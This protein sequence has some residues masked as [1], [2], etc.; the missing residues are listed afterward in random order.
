MEPLLRYEIIQTFKSDIDYRNEFC[1]QHCVTN[2][3]G[4]AVVRQ[5]GEETVF[6]PIGQK[7]TLHFDWDFKFI[8]YPCRGRF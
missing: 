3:I 6:H 1:V 7:C 2:I 8:K 4:S 5:L